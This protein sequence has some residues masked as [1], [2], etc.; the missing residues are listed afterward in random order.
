M[1]LDAYP[2]AASPPLRRSF[3]T[4]D[5]QLSAMLLGLRGATSAGAG[6]TDL[7]SG[8]AIYGLIEILDFAIKKWWF[9]VVFVYRYDESRFFG[10]LMVA[11]SQELL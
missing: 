5:S 6:G 7:G 1:K 8:L 11:H 4:G 3:L 2:L 9:S 10:L